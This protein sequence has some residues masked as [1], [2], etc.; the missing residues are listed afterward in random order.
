MIWFFGEFNRTKSLKAANFAQH[1][2]TSDIT[3]AG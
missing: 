2:T 3:E 1:L